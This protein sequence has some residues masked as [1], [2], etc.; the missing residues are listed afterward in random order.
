MKKV[1]II[2]PFYNVEEYIERSIK[3][4]VNQ[5]LQDIEIIL[6]ND[7]SKDGSEEIARDYQRR[8]PDKI[9]YLEKENG[10]L[11]DAR[12]YA[13]PYA[14]GE[15]IAFLDSDDYVEEEMYAEMYESARIDRADVVECDYLWEYPEETIESK[16]RTYKDRKDML[17]NARVVAWNK[18][19]KRELIERTRIKFPVGLRYEDVEFFYKLIPYINS[20]SIVK[21]P[22]IHYVQ[23]ENSISNTQTSKTADII[24]VL[25][26]VIDFYKENNIYENYKN[27]L[28]Y[29]YA[30]YLLCSSMLRMV[31]IEDKAERDKTINYAWEKLNTT[32]PKWKEN[33]YF[34]EKSLKNKYMLSVNDKT[35][36]LYEKLGRIRFIRK[37]IQERFA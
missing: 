31:M 33:K 35:L 12:N 32:F 24:Q 19:I 25:D 15:Y 7:G 20:I 21:R 23:R 8:Y 29:N 6:V 14:T 10:G 2:V 13:L 28:E 5:S 34:K 27:E 36:K 1:S 4:L 9:I 30:R 16:G 18:L 22:F 26:H 11:S 17:L 3:S 37:K